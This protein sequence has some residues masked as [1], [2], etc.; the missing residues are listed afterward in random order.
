MF[1]KMYIISKRKL[2]IKEVWIG[3]DTFIKACDVGE[4]IFF[5][6]P[7]ADA[8]LYELLCERGGR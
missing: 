5:D 7:S 3:R 4:F 1:E 6:K 2:T 8:K